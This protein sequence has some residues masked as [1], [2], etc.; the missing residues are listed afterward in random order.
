MSIL[1]LTCPL[2]TWVAT[3]ALKAL[4]RYA[5]QGRSAVQDFGAGGMP[6]NHVA[7]VSSVTT[8][9]VRLEGHDSP[10]AGIAMAL[11]LIVVFDATSLRRQLG[12]MAQRLN[13]LHPEEAPLRERTGHS[14]LE[15]MAGLIWGAVFGL[16]W[17]MVPLLFK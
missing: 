12:A 13:R 9:V 11:L 15:V 2:A 5:T 6:S 4:I 1:Y 17:S 8:V 7:I 16:A 10:A 14:W 3:G